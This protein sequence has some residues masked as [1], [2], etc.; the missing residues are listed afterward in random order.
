M[1]HRRCSSPFLSHVQTDVFQIQLL[2][3]T[4]LSQLE[5]VV[6]SYDRKVKEVGNVTQ[7]FKFNTNDSSHDTLTNEQLDAIPG[8]F[9][10]ALFS[11]MSGVGHV[12]GTSRGQV[13]LEEFNQRR[14]DRLFRAQAVLRQLTDSWLLPVGDGPETEITVGACFVCSQGSVTNSVSRSL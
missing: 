5:L 8:A 10:N 14:G 11:Y 9:K 7:L 12:P 3:T 6:T 13:E 2:E 4:T 1:Y